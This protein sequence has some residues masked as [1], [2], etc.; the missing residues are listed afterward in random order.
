MKTSTKIWLTVAAIAS[1]LGLTLALSGLMM[2]NGDFL[3]LSGVEYKTTVHEPQDRFDK[4]VIDVSTSD[5]KLLPSEDGKCR[6][7]CMETDKIIHSVS[8]RDET[9]VIGI[10]D[11]RRW[12]DHVTL[13]SKS[14]MLTLYLPLNEYS[15]LTVTA[16]TG[17]ISLSSVSVISVSAKVDTGRIKLSSVTCTDMTLS[18]DT[19]DVILNGVLADG[20]LS[21]DTDTGNVNFTDSDAA[22][23]FITV[24]TGNVS[25]SLLSEKIFTAKTDTG[26]VRVPDTD[27]GGRCY[28]ESD[29][30]NID[31]SLSR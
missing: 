26:R 17:N 13:F 22:D 27:S 14:P 21:I 29:T 7:V 4:I 3:K 23:I 8:V 25:G 5:V 16:N 11:N 15:S 31:I 2:C 19:G 12:F 10:E 20:N 24:D 1:V 18:S 9:L 28:I 30:G 6:V